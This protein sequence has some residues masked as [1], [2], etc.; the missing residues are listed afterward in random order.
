MGKKNQNQP[1]IVAFMV[2]VTQNPKRK[3]P[4]GKVPVHFGSAVFDVNEDAIHPI[5]I[6]NLQIREKYQ[7]LDKKMEE[8][9]LGNNLKLK[10]DEIFERYYRHPRLSLE[11]LNT[12]LQ[13]VNELL[14]HADR[15]ELLEAVVS[16]HERMLAEKGVIV[17]VIV[18]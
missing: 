6:R 2:G 5:T 10:V 18:E 7:I 3:T 11:G 4:E 9:P 15:V 1:V 14:N 12:E 8:S 13:I 17:P 16:S